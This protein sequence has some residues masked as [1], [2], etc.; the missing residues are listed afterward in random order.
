MDGL[1]RMGPSI[2]LLF[3]LRHIWRMESYRA[4]PKLTGDFGLILVT[5]SGGS[6]WLYC[7]GGGAF[8]NGP[9]VPDKKAFL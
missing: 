8:R 1:Y 7:P 5:Q 6:A 9:F 2:S 3:N 4:V